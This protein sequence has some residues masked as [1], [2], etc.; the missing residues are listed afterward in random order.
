MTERTMDPTLT[1]ASV[2]SSA[3]HNPVTTDLLHCTVELDKVLVY[4]LSVRYAPAEG[5]TMYEH[6]AR[7]GA[8]WR[9]GHAKARMSPPTC[10]HSP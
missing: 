7:N 8:L 4:A 1:E 3:L 2:A 10:R 5:L 6:F 9:S